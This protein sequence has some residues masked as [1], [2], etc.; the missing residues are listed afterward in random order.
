DDVELFCGGTL[1]GL[2]A[3]GYRVGV[4]DLTRGERS[5]QGTPE[6]RAREAGAA[7]KVL[8]LTLRQNLGLPDMGIGESPMADRAAVIGCLRR[9]RPELV[10]APWEV[11]AHPDHAAAGA[12]LRSSLFLANAVHADSDPPGPAFRPRAVL[13]YPMRVMFEGKP[14]LIVDT[15]SSI[16]TK[17]AAIACHA[18]QSPPDVTA[19][20]AFFGAQ[21]GTAAGEPFRASEP[22]GVADPLSHFRANTFG[23]AQ[24]L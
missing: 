3:Q 12:L 19:R 2:V 8:G 20:D 21:L 13:L 15:S 22:L 9:L 6:V 7:A 4:I 17:R 23:R 14:D 10:I 5:S 18:S 11:A 16:E 24:I 1:A